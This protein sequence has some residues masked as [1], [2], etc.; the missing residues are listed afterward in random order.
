MVP[1]CHLL[2]RSDSRIHKMMAGK[3]NGIELDTWMSCW[4]LGSM[5][6]NGGITY[7]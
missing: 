4:N 1:M 5:L 7:K 6:V 2:I 3:K